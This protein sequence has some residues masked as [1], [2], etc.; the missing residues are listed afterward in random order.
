MCSFHLH[1]PRLCC[2]F[3]FRFKAPIT[4]SEFEGCSTYIFLNL[5]GIRP[6]QPLS[7]YRFSLKSYGIIE[8]LP[9]PYLPNLKAKY[10]LSKKIGVCPYYYYSLFIG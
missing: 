9:L 6:I 3:A 2:I 10:Q 7:S 8:L 5:I 4:A 1:H